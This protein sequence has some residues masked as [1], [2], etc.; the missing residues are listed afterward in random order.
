MEQ[1]SPRMAEID[2]L[3]SVLFEKLAECH[4]NLGIV[5]A[6]YIKFYLTRGISFH[7]KNGKMIFFDIGA[8]GGDIRY[9]D[10]LIFDI[11][12]F[13]QGICRHLIERKSCHFI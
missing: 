9:S 6:D 7:F 4:E 11:S 2:W 12:C 1:T 8:V 13:E 3:A 5:L 10:I